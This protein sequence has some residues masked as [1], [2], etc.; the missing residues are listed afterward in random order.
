MNADQLQARQ[1]IIDALQQMHPNPEA[2]RAAAVALC[3]RV[4]EV[5]ESITDHGPFATSAPKDKPVLIVNHESLLG[6]R[7]AVMATCYG[8]EGWVISW[9]TSE[10]RK[11]DPEPVALTFDAKSGKFV[12]PEGATAELTLGTA[13][14]NRIA[15]HK[16]A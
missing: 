6:S 14:M 9:K 16:P 8:G 11:A 10:E 2:K 12:G 4:A 13:I 1:A 15:R 5:F 7:R 3:A